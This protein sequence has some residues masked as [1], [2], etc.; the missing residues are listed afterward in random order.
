MF[1]SLSEWHKALA[2]AF[3][4]PIHLADVRNGILIFLIPYYQNL[5]GATKPANNTQFSML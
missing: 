2:E 5:R 4:W 3:A 1:F